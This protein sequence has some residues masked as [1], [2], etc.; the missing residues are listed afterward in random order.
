MSGTN[1]KPVRG[2]FLPYITTYSPYIMMQHLYLNITVQPWS[3]SFT[4]DNNDCC[5][6]FGMMC[7]VRD[8]GGKN[9]Q[10]ISHWC[11]D[12]MVDPSGIVTF[13]GLSMWGSVQNVCINLLF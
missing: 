8:F 1:H 7:A 3:Q 11:V 4:T 13:N 5:D 9:G 12:V 2:H 10:S 6:R